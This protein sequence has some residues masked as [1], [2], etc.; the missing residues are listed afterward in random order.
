[1]EKLKV[2]LIGLGQVAESHLDGYREVDSVE[3]VA[4]AEVREDRLRKMVAAW[5]F[6][7]YTDYQEMLEKEDLDIA[8]ILT[9]PLSH[10]EITEKV[11]EH[12]VHILCE[13]PMTITLEDAGAMIETCESKKVKFC[14]GASYRF[15]PACRKSKEIIQEGTLG[16]ITLLMEVFV[17]GSGAHQ[18]KDLGPNFYPA[19]TPG[20]GGMGLVDHGIHLIDLFRWITEKEITYVA[21]RGNFTGGSPGSEFL[22]MIFENGTVGQLVYNDATYASDLPNEGSFSWGGGWDISGHLLPKGSWDAHAGSIRIHGEKG[23]LRVFHYANMLFL[24][25]EGR[26]VQIRVPDRPMPSQFA[27]QL[28]SFAKRIG[29]GKEPEVT[30]TDGMKALQVL[31]AGYESFETKRIVEMKPLD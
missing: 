21:G 23:A 4:G 28:E 27:L 17:G 6:K 14:Y 1:V 19:G 11:A 18:W 16:K 25:T 31:L 29:E 13:K 10:R 12:G 9:P 8:C 2:G 7:G 15:L 30:G 24:S 26:Q 5:G 22:T 20:G 3:V